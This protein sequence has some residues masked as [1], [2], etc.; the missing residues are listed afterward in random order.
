M[1]Y[2]YAC[3]SPEYTDWVE[4]KAMPGRKKILKQVQ[5]D[6]IRDIEE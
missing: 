5:N 2:D 6:K 3:R 1:H 4:S